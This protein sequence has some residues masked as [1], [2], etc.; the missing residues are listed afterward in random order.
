MRDFYYPS[1]GKGTIHG[2]RWE[3]EGTVKG[4]VQ[5]IHGI[6]EYA[7]RYDD[8]ARY[9]N[10]LGYLVVAEDHMGHGKSGDEE[11]IQGYFYGGWFSAVRDSVQLMNNIQEEFPGVP[12]YVFGHSMGSFMAR[13]ILIQYPQCRLDGAMIC[14][15][16]WMP[17]AVLKAGH[18]IAKIL[19]RSGKDI[20]PNPTLHNLMFGS[21]NKRIDHPRTDFD[22][23][24]RD[25]A[26]V[27]RYINDPLCG[28]METAGLA[29]AMLEGIIYIQKSEHLKQ[30][31]KNVPVYFISGG[32]DPVGD[33][34]AGVRKAEEKFR[35][36]GMITVDS[37]I[38]PLCRHEIL[39]EINR[40]E[41]YRCVGD[42]LNK[43]NP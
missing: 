29:K 30:M 4:I 42:W 18:T 11:C 22:W 38:F 2:C 5:I 14:G 35:N 27:D 37:R 6:A 20:K 19:C 8:F 21:Y 3:P 39:N 16:G 41:V 10:S 31:N 17:G 25:R 32:D 40:D 26:Q 24:N 12:Y 15:T 28:F 43:I 13:T 7:A 23:L 33:Y 34:G 9:L 1:C 36:C